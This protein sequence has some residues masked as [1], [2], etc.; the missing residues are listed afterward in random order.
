MTLD[1]VVEAP[2]RGCAALADR[3]LHDLLTARAAEQDLILLGRR[4][5]EDFAEFWPT[6]TSPLAAHVNAT[7]KLVVSETLAEVRWQNAALMEEPI[8]QELPKLKQANGRDIAVMGTITL[9]QSLLRRGLVDELRLLVHPVTVGSGR[10]LVEGTLAEG[11]LQLIAA[12]ALSSG[13]LDLAY[14]PAQRDLLDAG[15][16]GRRNGAGR[17]ARHRARR[18]APAESGAIVFA[19]SGCSAPGAWL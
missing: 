7:R 3:E 4:T 1:G 18:H 19:G 14:A 8:A 6:S 5:Y 10:R 15:R 11:Q 16:S 12:S 17:Q 13:V 9:V 2:E